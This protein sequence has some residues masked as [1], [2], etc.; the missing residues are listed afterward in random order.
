MRKEDVI[1]YLRIMGTEKR[2]VGVGVCQR[3]ALNP[4]AP[5]LQF[6][7][8]TRSHGGHR[9]SPAGDIRVEC[10]SPITKSNSD[11]GVHSGKA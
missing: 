5:Y 3:V 8:R 4:G 1:G 10:V 11:P 2:C 6:L 9:V 7:P